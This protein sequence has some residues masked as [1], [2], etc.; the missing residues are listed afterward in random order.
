[1]SKEVEAAL[2]AFLQ[3][4]QKSQIKY[5]QVGILEFILFSL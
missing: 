2:A 1:M 4:G 5:K 3:K